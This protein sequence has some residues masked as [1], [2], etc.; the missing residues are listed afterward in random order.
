MPKGWAALPRIVRWLAGGIAVLALVLILTWALFVPVTDWLAH[1]D[2]GAARGPAL[3]AARDDARGRLLTLA[4]GLLAAGALLF[5]ARNFILSREGQVTDRYSKAVEQLGSYNKLDVRLGGIYALERIARDSARDYATVMEVLTAFI[6]EHSHEPYVSRRRLTPDNVVLPNGRLYKRLYRWLIPE[7]RD[8]E[9]TT[10]PDVQAALT[11]VGRRNIRRDIRRIDLRGADLSTADLHGANLRRANLMDVNLRG[12]NLS[13]ADLA[14]ASLTNADLRGADVSMA[15]LRGAEISF[16]H[17]A[18]ANFSSA[19]LRDARL[20]FARLPQAILAY[21][22][23]N[24]A[25]LNHADLT[26]ASL[27]GTNLANADLGDANLRGA[28]LHNTI[29]DLADTNLLG[30]N[31]AGANLDGVRWPQNRPVPQDWKLDAQTGRL[32]PRHAPHMSDGKRPRRA[33]QVRRMSRVGR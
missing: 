22:D 32:T 2:V 20:P 27:A 3:L 6:R 13:E 30:A 21:A 12:A 14:G 1:H 18:R 15:N 17:L 11:V 31:L 10:R 24:H 29:P 4:A 5:T 16:A 25:D 23:L 33:G 28:D 9:R 7:L 8:Q 26:E 19:N